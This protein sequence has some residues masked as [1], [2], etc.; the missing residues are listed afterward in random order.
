MNNT[1]ITWQITIVAYLME[2]MK[3]PGIWYITA[4]PMFCNLS[5][6]DIISMGNGHILIEFL[7]ERSG[8]VNNR[9]KE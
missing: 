8:L 5:P 1:E 3:I 6:Q 2:K 7:E 9:G 4:S